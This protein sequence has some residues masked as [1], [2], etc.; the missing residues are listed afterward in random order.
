MPLNASSLSMLSYRL[1]PLSGLQLTVPD[2]PV[3][4]KCFIVSNRITIPNVSAI[5]PCHLWLVVV[6]NWLLGGIH[7]LWL[8]SV[9]PLLSLS[10]WSGKWA[11]QLE[12]NSINIWGTLNV[13]RL[14]SG[15][16]NRLIMI[17]PSWEEKTLSEQKVRISTNQVPDKRAAWSKKASWR[18]LPGCKGR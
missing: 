15:L 5:F 6:A 12:R 4:E 8:D 13:R 7:F 11:S 10:S 18:N 14:G 16:E 3:A 2:E 1:Q 17:L 9:V